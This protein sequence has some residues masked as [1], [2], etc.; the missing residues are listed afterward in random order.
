MGV[1]AIAESYASAEACLDVYEDLI[2]ISYYAS[3]CGGIKFLTPEQ[4]AFHRSSGKLRTTGEKYHRQPVAGNK[5]NNKIAIVTGGAQ[6]FGAGIAESLFALNLNVV[7][8]DLNE[9]TGNTFVSKLSSKKS[10]NKAVFVKTDVSDPVSV[11]DLII[12]TVREFG[13]L[14][15]MVSNAGILKGRRT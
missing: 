2:K 1:F 7:I 9:E 13:G 10:S 5:L 11:K 4:V 12:A 3:Q 8:A 15:L 14:D 6:G